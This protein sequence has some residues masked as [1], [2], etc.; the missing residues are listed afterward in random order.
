M[1]STTVDNVMKSRTNPHQNIIDHLCVFLPMQEKK[2]NR[3]VA[4][5][6]ASLVVYLK[7]WAQALEI[8]FG[9]TS[10]QKKI[11]IAIDTNTD[12]YAQTMCVCVCVRQAQMAR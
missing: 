6:V 3:E 5:N 4:P 7:H 11:Y 1:T 8:F 10:F 2:K 9:T 12:I